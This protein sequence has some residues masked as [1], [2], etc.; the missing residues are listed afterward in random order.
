MEK[1]GKNKTSAENE[2]CKLK[3]QEAGFFLNLLNIVP[4]VQVSDHNLTK[5]GFNSRTK[6]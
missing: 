4:A 1:V 2:N 5:V 6:A 3:E